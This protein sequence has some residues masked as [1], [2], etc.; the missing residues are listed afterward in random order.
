MLFN[1]IPS[2][3]L[4][5]TLLAIAKIVAIMATI[6]MAN[7]DSSMAITSNQLKSLN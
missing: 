3:V 7:V 2:I 5:M 1:R 6:V 4:L